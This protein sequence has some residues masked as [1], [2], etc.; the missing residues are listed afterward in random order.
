M[1]VCM[2]KS[3]QKAAPAFPTM[4]FR[5]LFAFLACLAFTACE[6]VRHD[7]ATGVREK[8]TG[9]TYSVRVFTSET[10]TVF[11]AARASAEQLGFRITRAGSAQGVIEG[12]SAL[13]SDDRLR[14]SRQRTIKVRLTSAEGGTKVAVLFTE[15]IEDN[16]EKGAG[17]GTEASLR[18]SPLYETFFGTMSEMLVR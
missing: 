12:V 10:R 8:V 18:N 4:I 11:D 7:I 1:I 14:S 17:Q 9:P 6:S 13:D 3:R 15:V 16:F 2:P 5:C